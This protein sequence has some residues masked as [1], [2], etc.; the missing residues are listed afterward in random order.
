MRQIKKYAN[1]RL[2]DL[3]D[4]CYINNKQ[5]YD[6]IAKGEK[7]KIIDAVSQQDITAS[8]LLDILAEQKI[9]PAVLRENF[10]MELLAFR[11]ELLMDLLGNYLEKSLQLFLCHQALFR[12]RMLDFEGDSPLNLLNELIEQQEK[13]LKSKE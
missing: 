5:V 9:N 8:I 13:I 6:F 11:D 12:K 1:R 2:Y 7:I 4:N 10:L 3:Q